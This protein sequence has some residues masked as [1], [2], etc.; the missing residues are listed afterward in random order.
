MAIKYLED[1]DMPSDSLILGGNSAGAH[2]AMMCA[3]DRE[4]QKKY[5][6]DGEKIKGVISVAGIP[7]PTRLFEN[8]SNAKLEKIIQYFTYLPNVEYLAKYAPINFLDRKTKTPILCIHGLYDTLSPFK[9]EQN[10]I[11]KLNYVTNEKLGSMYCLKSRKYQHIE[12]TA[13]IFTQNYKNSRIRK[14]ILSWL[15]D[16]A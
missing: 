8:I 5:G 14:V 2:A 13:G 10:F 12:L 1:S 6:I 16:Q 4:S 11:D 15:E 7:D 9:A 3:Y